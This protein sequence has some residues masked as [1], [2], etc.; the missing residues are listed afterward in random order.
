LSEEEKKTVMRGAESLI[1]IVRLAEFSVRKMTGPEAELYEF[2]PAEIERIAKIGYKFWFSEPECLIGW[3]N[4]RDELKE[5]AKNLAR[6]IP[7]ILAK[8]ELEVYR[9]N[10]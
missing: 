6:A 7:E 2:S 9:G 3:H 4:L 10:L 8:G 5:A 1:T